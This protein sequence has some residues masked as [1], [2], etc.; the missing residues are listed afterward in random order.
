MKKRGETMDY[1]YVNILNEG[2][3]PWVGKNGPLFGYKLSKA[4]LPLIQRDSRVILQIVRSEEDIEKAKREYEAR[5]QPKS[6]KIILNETPKSRMSDTATPEDEVIIQVVKAIEEPS[7]GII[8]TPEEA[9]ILEAA[10]EVLD[11]EELD[12]ILDSVCEKTT[13]AD[14]V[15]ADK[16]DPEE[17]FK[18]YTDK[19]LSTMTKAQMKKVLRGRGYLEGPYAGKY[20]DTVE[21]LKDKV[22]KT[23]TFKK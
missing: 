21:M 16:T 13:F 11:D 6:E 15:I 14:P 22:R 20:H 1:I 4:L 2:R 10:A 23:Q 9:M 19:E 8:E 17:P 18:F 7:S 5:K 3:I 12:K